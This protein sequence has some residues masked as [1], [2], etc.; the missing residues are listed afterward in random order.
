MMLKLSNAFIQLVDERYGSARTVLCD[1]LQ[2]REEIIL[3]SR[4]IP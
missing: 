3:S 1:P 4:K 2:D